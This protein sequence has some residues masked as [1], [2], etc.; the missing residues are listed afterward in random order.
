[1]V[2]TGLVAAV[3]LSSG[4]GAEASTPTVNYGGLCALGVANLLSPSP[5]SV[6]VGPGGSV[7]IVNN[8]TT[9][10]GKASLDVSS[11]NGQTVRLGPGART[12]FTYPESGS[13]KSYT[14]NAKCA[15]VAVSA[16]TRVT[17][18]AAPPQEKP[19][20]P[21]PAPG[22][23]N[24]NAAGPGSGPGT[25][26]DPGTGSGGSGTAPGTGSGGSTGGKG[27]VPGSV[28]GARPATGTALPPGFANPPS[29]LSAPGAGNLPIP[30][31]SAAV[32]GAP[33]EASAPE[34]DLFGTGTQAGAADDTQAQPELAASASDT[35]PGSTTRMLLIIV[36]M[37]L[38]LGVGAAALRAVRDSRVPSA[39]VL[40]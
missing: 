21:A 17:V 4:S 3:A 5:S 30:D 14:V 1:V 2:A 23:G 38:F 29:T 6:S 25:G 33:G 26:S 18:A 20:E 35:G 37:V 39:A 28:P 27:T 31:V 10:L 36:A 34:V 16:P 11:G 7:A 12:V 32:P 19:A 24:D 15:A 8:A 40:S 22:S 9:L 13:V